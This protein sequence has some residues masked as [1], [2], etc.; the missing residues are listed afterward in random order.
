MQVLRLTI[1]EASQSIFR[2]YGG[3]PVPDWKLRRVVDVL[4]SQGSLDVQRIGTYRT[5]SA[6]DLW[7]IADE[8]RRLGWL[9]APAAEPVTC[10]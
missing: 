4:E 7:V 8:L 9:K 2:Q 5:V 1:R 10:S 6:D 3:R